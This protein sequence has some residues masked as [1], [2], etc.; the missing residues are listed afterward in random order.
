MRINNYIIL[1][2]SVS[3]LLGCSGTSK[4]PE[5]D[6]L[7]VGHTISVKKGTAPKKVRNKIKSELDDLIRPMPNKSFFGMRP[8]IF[9]YNLAGEVKKEKGF[10]YWLRNKVG[11][12]PVLFSKVDLDYN[13]SVLRNFA[14]NRGYFKTRVSADSTVRNQRVTAEYTVIPKKSIKF[15][16]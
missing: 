2:F 16:N 12:E 8:S 6:L 1:L 15:K 4:I 13:A 3:L 11:E 5:G 9:F 14:E 7:Y 10:R